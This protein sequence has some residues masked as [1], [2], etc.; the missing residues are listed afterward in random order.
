M[1][2]ITW[3]K[4]A[5][6]QQS[7]LWCQL[8]SANKRPLPSFARQASPLAFK[9]NSSYW[10]SPPRNSWQGRKKR[11]DSSFLCSQTDEGI[12]HLE[13]GFGC[14]A[15]LRRDRNQTIF[16]AAAASLGGGASVL[17]VPPLPTPTLPPVPSNSHQSVTKY[18]CSTPSLHLPQDGPTHERN[19]KKR[20]K[21]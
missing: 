2:K 1:L 11:R 12:L 18:R 3:H 8:C 10:H 5:S 20:K 21:E 15:K 14:W 9:N 16:R 6:R 13:S 7:P 17:R 4:A 19:V